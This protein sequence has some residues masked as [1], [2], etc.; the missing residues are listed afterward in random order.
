MQHQKR[1]GFL[2]HCTKQSHIHKIYLNQKHCTAKVK[3]KEENTI[4]TWGKY[5]DIF[6]ISNA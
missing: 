4:S 6:N 2:K 1:A 3:P 5:L